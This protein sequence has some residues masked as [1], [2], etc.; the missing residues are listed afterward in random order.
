MDQIEKEAERIRALYQGIKNEIYHG[1][2]LEEHLQYV[3]EV[4]EEIDKKIAAVKAEG[5]TCEAF[6]IIRNDLF[7]LKYQILERT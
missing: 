1:L 5:R 7:Y 2:N 3:N 6:D 4:I